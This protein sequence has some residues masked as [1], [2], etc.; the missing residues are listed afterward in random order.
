MDVDFLGP[1][2]HHRH[3][4]GHHS[5]T[6]RSVVADFEAWSRPMHAGHGPGRGEE[7]PGPGEQSLTNPT[8]VP[9]ENDNVSNSNNLA[10]L[11]KRKK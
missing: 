2:G 5:K 8:S 9:D 3:A 1:L 11:R 4:L 7:A 6:N 10:P